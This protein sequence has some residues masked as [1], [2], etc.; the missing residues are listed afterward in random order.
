MVENSYLHPL[1]KR[2]LFLTGTPSSFCRRPSTTERGLDSHGCGVEVGRDGRLVLSKH[3]L[4]RLLVRALR[5][6]EERVLM[7]TANV[8]G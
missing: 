5:F 1:L 3:F 7:R 2:Y 8:I 4:C 6:L